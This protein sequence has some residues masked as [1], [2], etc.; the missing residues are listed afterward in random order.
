MLKVAKEGQDLLQGLLFAT[1]HDKS[2][3]ITIPSC[4]GQLRIDHWLQQPKNINY[5]LSRG[6]I[7][8]AGVRRH[9]FKKFPCSPAPP[10][11]H[12][13]T[14]LYWGQD[15]SMPVNRALA[16]CT[17]AAPPHHLL[18]GEALV[19][20]HLQLDGQTYVSVDR[21]DVQLVSAVLAW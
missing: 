2:E 14:V 4:D 8:V 5:Y 3:L 17:R 20:K 15:V 19:I 21:E 9:T 16:S 11:D 12:V 1:G 10:F 13:Y 18:R 6:N 7:D